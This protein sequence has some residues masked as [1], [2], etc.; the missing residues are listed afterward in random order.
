MKVFCI[1]CQHYKKSL[2]NPNCKIA[3]DNYYQRCNAP[4]NN[5]DDHASE[6]I[7]KESIP[8]IINRFNDC[9]WYDEKEI[10]A[11]DSSSSSSGA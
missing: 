2:V 10:I 7:G 11:N 1:N 3:P 5:I 4:E 8:S 6:D 9:P